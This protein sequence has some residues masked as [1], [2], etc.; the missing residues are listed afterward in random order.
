MMV[1]AGI[2]KSSEEYMSKDEFSEYKLLLLDNAKRND[3]DHELISCK[4]DKVFEELVA[5][6]IKSGIWGGI[7]GLL[8]SLIPIVVYFIRRS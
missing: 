2:E 8:G 6:K 5:L 3:H 4:L 1:P 7:A